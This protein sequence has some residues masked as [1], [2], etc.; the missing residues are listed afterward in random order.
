MSW[1][2]L[3]SM[4][5]HV[6]WEADDEAEDPKSD[7]GL[8]KRYRLTF[9][10][11]LSASRVR[12]KAWRSRSTCKCEPNN[13]KKKKNKEDHDDP[14]SNNEAQDSAVPDKHICYACD[15]VRSDAYHEQ[16]PLV[17]GKES[18]PSLCTGCRRDRQ[19]SIEAGAAAGDINLQQAQIDEWQW[20]TTC[21]NLRSDEYHAMYLFNNRKM[22]PWA[23]ICGK[24]MIIEKGR[25]R[26]AWLRSFL[27]AQI[28]NISKGRK[29]GPLRRRSRRNP[30]RPPDS[31][32]H[33]EG[34]HSADH[35]P[36]KVDEPIDNKN[37]GEGEQRRGA[38][39]G[40]HETHAEE[41]SHVH[42]HHDEASKR[43]HVQ[44]S[45]R[46]VT[47]ETDS[48]D[49]EWENRQRER[50][51]QRKARRAHLDSQA[52]R[53][54]RRLSDLR[55]H[56]YPLL[57]EQN[58]QQSSAPVAAS[59]T[60]HGDHHHHHQPESKAPPPPPPEEGRNNNNKP[61]AAAPKVVISDT[62]SAPEL[63]PQ[64][65]DHHHHDPKEAEVKAE[66][67]LCYSAHASDADVVDPLRDNPWV[68][69]TFVWAPPPP[70]P[71][72]P[73]SHST[74]TPHRHHRHSTGGNADHDDDD[75]DDHGDGDEFVPCYT[76]W[77]PI[78]N[79]RRKVWE[80][81]SDE[82]REIERMRALLHLGLHDDM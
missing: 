43:P 33:T 8:K 48:S 71:P 23:E 34:N 5:N 7:P 68:S 15:K 11:S 69:D 46:G 44:R 4:T 66:A 75:D 2:K 12:A 57:R 73:F 24:C 60:D 41:S 82:E 3:V 27:A 67:E 19:E 79:D 52:D 20:C 26:T 59:D 6:D 56:L 16:Y 72:P 53:A 29:H 42:H 78:F 51:E 65:H 81:D 64:D 40:N 21:G 9:N 38:V 37:Q 54:L 13:N 39:S 36:K 76:H 55:D 1:K 14:K 18:I 47:C 17:P 74:T 70:P 61:S 62:Y 45:F 30:L 25:T 35:L 31:S 22:P 77:S 32:P 10:V 58:S 49:E 50:K 63:S 28:N 80:V